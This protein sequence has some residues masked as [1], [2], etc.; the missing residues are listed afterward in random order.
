MNSSI[1]I[2]MGIRQLDPA[3][4]GFPLIV[5][6]VENGLLWNCGWRMPPCESTKALAQLRATEWGR[7]GDQT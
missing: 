7:D 6:L 2:V 3:S 1:L 4:R 5:S